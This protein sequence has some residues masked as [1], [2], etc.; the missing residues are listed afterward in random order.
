M[1]GEGIYAYITVKEGTVIDADLRDR[2][3]VHVRES[4]RPIATPDVIHFANALP[5]RAAVKS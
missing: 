1:K 2:L 5:K 3:F 4:I